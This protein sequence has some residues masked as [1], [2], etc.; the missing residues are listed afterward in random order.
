MSKQPKPA[1]A[2]RWRLIGL[3]TAPPAAH[4]APLQAVPPRSGAL[5][6]PARGWASGSALRVTGPGASRFALAAV[7]HLCAQLRQMNRDSGS[8]RS[9]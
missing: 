4:P 6:E 2:V 7:E 5:L 3:K 9:S 1:G 8:F